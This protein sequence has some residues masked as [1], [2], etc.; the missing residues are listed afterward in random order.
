MADD[1]AFADSRRPIEFLLEDALII[2]AC[3]G[4][5][6][7]AAWALTLWMNVEPAWSPALLGASTIT[8]FVMA[9]AALFAWYGLLAMLPRLELGWRILAYLFGCAVV[10]VT[11]HT[12][13]TLSHPLTWGDPWAAAEGAMFAGFSH[14]PLKAPGILLGLVIG[15][16]LIWKLRELRL[17]RERRHERAVQRE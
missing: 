17:G 12:L 9:L 2:A 15:L 11:L 1:L 8:G 13:A 14:L 10:D 3:T 4:V 6:T 7:T 5:V 16:A